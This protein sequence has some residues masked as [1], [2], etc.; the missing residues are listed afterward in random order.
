MAKKDADNTKGIGILILG[1]VGLLAVVGLILLFS[2]AKLSGKAVFADEPFE[3]SYAGG[4]IEWPVAAKTVLWECTAPV[5]TMG[6]T[7]KQVG[8]Y[9]KP[10]CAFEDGAKAWWESKGWVCKEA[11]SKSY[12]VTAQNLR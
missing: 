4:N 12:C 9:Q 7:G 6:G 11:T 10:Q 5:N 3:E 8:T 1:V 2:Q